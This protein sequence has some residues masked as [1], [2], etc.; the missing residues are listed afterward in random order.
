MKYIKILILTS[1]LSITGLIVFSTRVQAAPA[2][3]QP[4]DSDIYYTVSAGSTNGQ[5][6]NLLYSPEVWI[7]IYGGTNSGGSVR[8]IHGNHCN[9]GTGWDSNSYRPTI[10]ELHGANP[11]GSIRLFDV[12]NSVSNTQQTNAGGTGCGTVTL[13]IPAGALTQ[14]SD[15]SH[16]SPFGTRLFTGIIKAY[17][18]PV[19]STLNG[20]LNVFKVEGNGYWT[21]SIATAGWGISSTQTFLGRP[22]STATDTYN[23]PFKPPCSSFAGSTTSIN[24]TLRWFDD[25]NGT[26]YQPPF[27]VQLLEFDEGPGLNLTNTR[28]IYERSGEGAPAQTN[29]TLRKG[30]KYVWQWIGMTNKN[31]VQVYYPFESVDFYLTCPSTPSQYNLSASVSLSPDDDLMTAGSEQAAKAAGKMRTEGKGYVMQPGDIVEFRFNV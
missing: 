5:G 1:I 6:G 7:R 13:N 18:N 2:N 16:V 27:T 12:R 31:G 21:G 10:F 22:S 9:A 11:D 26:S 3:V 17:I 15:P 28:I 23:L 30:K 19:N 20:P 24:A 29:V 4:E 25:D 8:F 14:S